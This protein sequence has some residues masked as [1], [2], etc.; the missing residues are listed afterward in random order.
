MHQR[1]TIRFRGRVERVLDEIRLGAKTYQLLE[2]LGS[3]ERERY[4]AFDRL[5]GPQGDYRAIHVLP[6]SVEVEQQL[7]VL[8]RLADLRNNNV[9]FIVEYHAQRDRVYLVVAWIW[10]RSLKEHLERVRAG[11]EPPVSAFHACRLVRGLAHGLCQLHDAWNVNHGDIRPANLILAPQGKHLSTIDFGT[12]WLTERARGRTPGDGASGPY[13]APEL[14]ETQTTPDFRSDQFSLSVVWYE[15]LT[16]QVPYD[17]AGG[18]AGLA[19]LRA[20]LAGTLIP[21]SRIPRANGHVPKGLWKALD[22]A[23]CRGLALAPNDR[24]A[25]RRTWLDAL[26]EIHVEFRQRQ[27]LGGINRRVADWLGKWLGRA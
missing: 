26:D 23:V 5:A 2:R 9:P 13:T 8:K 25:Q 1:A 27:K 11:R 3:G 19:D 16:G 12:G 7:A 15:L 17:G 10:G 24:F 22:G 18:K 4:R 6:R 21:P 14:L 20:A